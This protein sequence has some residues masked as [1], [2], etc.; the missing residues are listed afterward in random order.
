MSL[1]IT[2]IKDYLEC[3]DLA[4]QKMQQ[5]IKERFLKTGGICKEVKNA[6]EKEGN[7]SLRICTVIPICLIIRHPTLP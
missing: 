2:L 3:Y 4:K 1:D 6:R 5:L 7:S